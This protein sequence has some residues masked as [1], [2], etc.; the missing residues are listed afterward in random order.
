M[1]RSW[2]DRLRPASFRGVPFLV[3]D[4]DDESGTRAQTHEYPNRDV[5]YTEPLGRKAESFTITAFVIGDDYMDKRDALKKVCLDGIPGTLIHP[6]MDSI[7]VVCTLYQCQERASVGRQ[8]SFTLTFV[9]AGKQIFPDAI[10]DYIGQTKGAAGL[11]KSANSSNFISKFA[12]VSKYTLEMKETVSGAV[13]SAAEAAGSAIKIANNAINAAHDIVDTGLSVIDTVTGVVDQL[14]DLSR[15]AAELLN[16][17]DIIAARL[18]AAGLIFSNFMSGIDAI[19]GVKNSRKTDIDAQIAYNNPDTDDG[20]AI[21]GSMQALDAFSR[22]DGIA[23]TAEIISDMDFADPILAKDILTGFISDVD[24]LVGSGAISD[25][26]YDALVNC[27]SCVMELIVAQIL[28]LPESRTVVLPET[29]PALVA[30]YNL[31]D[32]SSRGDEIVAQNNIKHPG[33][34]PANKELTVLTQ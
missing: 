12:D 26:M 24:A 9:E 16:A 1:P 5:P 14:G 2:K 34:V 7:D 29:V 4:A 8:A 33:F 10:E 21:I 28:R 30:A 20:A 3:E 13:S 11:L 25:D 18:D 6:T 22:A 27:Q 31:Y 23:A 17:P 19:N 15:N 32:D